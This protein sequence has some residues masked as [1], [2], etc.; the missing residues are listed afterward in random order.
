MPIGRYQVWLAASAA[1]LFYS[2][3]LVYLALKG[4]SPVAPMMIVALFG[5]L[6]LPVTLQ[7]GRLWPTLSSPLAAWAVIAVFVAT[8]GFLRSSQSAIALERYVDICGGA[9]F[10]LLMVFLFADA[11]SLAASRTTLVACVIVSVTLNAYDISHPFIFSP[12]L[13]RAGGLYVNPNI[14]ALALVFGLIVTIDVVPSKWRAIY[15]V[16][17]GLGVALTLSRAGVLL[18]GMV[19]FFLVVR[20]RVEW[21]RLAVTVAMVSL[22]LWMWLIIGG[23]LEQVIEA[24]GGIRNLPLDRLTMTAAAG[25]VSA[26]TRH[27]VAWAAARLFEKNPIIGAGLGA[28]SE[29][30]LPVSAH[31]MYLR[32][33]AELGVAGVVLFPAL[34]IAAGLAAKGGHRFTSHLYAVAWFVAGMFSHNLLEERPELVTLAIVAAAT[35]LGSDATEGS[36][37]SLSRASTE[38]SDGKSE[39][40]L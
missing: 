37:P 30:A 25:D 22:G 26:R 7:R 32:L 20:R 18:W 23:H 17:V 6:A 34:G 16:V 33:A 21:R 11:E 39:H 3:V 10:L 13:G 19:S 27:E 31:N 40:L 2:N 35:L 8:I 14:S 4:L 29:W 9:A 38:G 1:V 24:V 12:I 28:T 36:P 15:V 5:L